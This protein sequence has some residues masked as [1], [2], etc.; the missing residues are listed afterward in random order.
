M[1]ITKCLFLYSVW[2]RAHWSLVLSS[3]RLAGPLNGVT[4]I[5][6]TPVT[7][8][9]MIASDLVNLAVASRYEDQRSSPFCRL[10]HGL[11]R[12]YKPACPQVAPPDRSLCTACVR[13]VHVAEPFASS[14]AADLAFSRSEEHTSELQSL[15]HLV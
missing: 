1:A 2:G 5:V 15:R 12:S 11:L 4:P 3:N 10:N 8:I 13:G 9:G 6:R 7:D 14:P